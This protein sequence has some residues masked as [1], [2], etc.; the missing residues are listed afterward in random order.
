ME[1]GNELSAYRLEQAE[2]CLRS[3][4]ALLA[5]DDYK[6]TANR[7]KQKAYEYQKTEEPIGEQIQSAPLLSGNYIPDYPIA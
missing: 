6:G 2:R 3:A 1:R 4:R 5:D 7:S